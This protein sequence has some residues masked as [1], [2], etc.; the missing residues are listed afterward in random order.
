MANEKVILRRGPHNSI[1]QTKV[2][3]TILV[4]TDTGNVFVDDTTAQDGRIQLSGKYAQYD[5]NNKP[6]VDK[7]DK[8]EGKD[9]ST[10]DYT[11]EDKE[12]LSGIEEGAN[13]IVVDSEMSSTSENPVQNKVIHDSLS[14]VTKFI[15][16]FTIDQS[17]VP[18]VIPEGHS[19]EEY[20]TCTCD[21]TFAEIETAISS[22]RP[23]EYRVYQKNYT[24]TYTTLEQTSYKRNIQLT[25]KPLVLYP[26]GNI[27]IT[28]LPRYVKRVNNIYPNDDNGFIT[29][30]TSD[31]ENDSGYITSAAVENADWDESDTSSKSYIKNRT[32]YRNISVQ[33]LVTSQS[34][35]DNAM[36]KNSNTNL[37]I[38][39]DMWTNR[40]PPFTID[41]GD[42]SVSEGDL[43]HYHLTV[44]MNNSSS[45]VIEG[46]T[47]LVALT[48]AQEGTEGTI[49][50][51][52]LIGFKI[53]VSTGGSIYVAFPHSTSSLQTGYAYCTE[54]P[55]FT[56]TI[57][58]ITAQSVTSYSKLD[59][60]YIPSDIQAA[61]LATPVYIDGVKFDGSNDISRFA[62]C[63]SA[64]DASEK[65]CTIP[66]LP[67]LNIKTGTII[68][69]LFKNGNSYTGNNLL[70]TVGNRTRQIMYRGTYLDGDEAIL[71]KNQVLNFVCKGSWHIVGALPE[72]LDLSN[73]KIDDGS[74]D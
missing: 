7:V 4:E 49:V 42:V 31:I 55:N 51:V 14:K 34:Y 21:K 48:E 32:H 15:V 9:L 70:L 22:N 43:I 71:S 37:T 44:E 58:N 73:I 29:L 12:K 6:L 72:K 8:V 1:P 25:V 53:N 63:E 61:A 23:I 47:N 64:A 17:S 74:I 13:K 41:Q 45:E 16:N 33:T 2:P 67:S 20:Y 11:N 30:K 65:V 57:H 54:S 5:L 19:R 69:V 26:D 40:T 52:S 39:G 36:T 10:N 18:I 35:L 59:K 27:I 28:E 66:G 46:D 24:D 62:V 60:N 56:L 3:G 38:G 68:T 50:S